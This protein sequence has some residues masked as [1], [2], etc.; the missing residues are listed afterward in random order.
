MKRLRRRVFVGR[1]L[2][3]GVSAV[4]PTTCTGCSLVP[5]PPKPAKFPR[6]GAL[7]P[8]PGP[9]NRVEWAS[10]RD[11]LAKAGWIEGQTVTIES[12]SAEGRIDRLPAL[13]AE[14]VALPVD[15]IATLSSPATLA[16]QKATSTIPIVFSGNN[17]PVGSGFVQSLARPGGN[18]TGT[19]QVGTALAGTRLSLLK[20]LV[21]GLA[22][23]PSWT[24]RPARPVT[25]RSACPVRSSTRSRPPLSNSVWRSSSSMCALKPISSPP[26]SLSRTGRPARCWWAATPRYS[27]PALYSFSSQ[28]EAGGLLS[29]GPNVGEL[30]RRAAVYYGDKILRG[31]GPAELPVEHPTA[32]DLA[33]NPSD[34]AAQ[35]TEWVE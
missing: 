28:V 29:Y 5:A 9:V 10:F 13:A 35:V 24:T 25:G 23:W 4:G 3:L 1:G 20:E 16:A 32:F 33:T 7:S 21:P 15:L 30:F 14:L 6:F 19:T 8:D 11:G 27:S 2:G 22:R 31:V 34:V 12:R 17:D 18:L 26:S